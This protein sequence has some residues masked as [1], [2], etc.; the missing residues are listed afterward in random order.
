LSYFHYQQK[1]DITTTTKGTIIAN[2]TELFWES[3]D[4]I[5]KY[6]PKNATLAVFPEG[7]GINYFTERNNPLTYDTLLPSLI[8]IVGEEEIIR[9]MERTDLDYIV[10]LHRLTPLCKYK[11]F[12]QDYAKQ[13]AKWIDRNY[14]L[15]KQ[16]GAKPFFSYRFGMAIFKKN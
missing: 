5:E 14:H 12:G 8:E 11:L 1:T 13:I 16:F 4:Y 9:T 15:V 7:L 10:L 6:I 3:I 2:N